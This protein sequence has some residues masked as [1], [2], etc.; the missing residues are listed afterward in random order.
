MERD[1]LFWKRTGNRSTSFW[2]CLAE[3]THLNQA[4]RRLIGSYNQR[5][6]T[7]KSIGQ[8]KAVSHRPG[9]LAVDPRVHG[10]DNWLTGTIATLRVMGYH[11]LLKLSLYLGL[12]YLGLYYV[13]FHPRA[14][15]SSVIYDA[16]MF[17]I[18]FETFSGHV[19]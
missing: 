11:H 19:T 12:L 13:G 6:N 2:T 15:N 5:T 18:H 4:A 3:L 14:R 17:Q 1:E 16:R 10:P 7:S 8:K 9:K